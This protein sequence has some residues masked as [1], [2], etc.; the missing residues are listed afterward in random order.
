MAS[1]MLAWDADTAFTIIALPICRENEQKAITYAKNIKDT[2]L[3]LPLTMFD[4]HSFRRLQNIFLRQILS[5]CI[6][7]CP[8]C[9]K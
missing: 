7:K 6:S 5:L 3:I 8:C 2:V 1:D 9:G 4:I